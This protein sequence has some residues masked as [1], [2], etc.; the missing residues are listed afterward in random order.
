MLIEEIRC[1][2]RAGEAGC[3]V[4]WECGGGRWRVLDAEVDAA[5]AIA[6]NVA[7][8]RENDVAFDNEG[9]VPSTGVV[10]GA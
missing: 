7:R 1:L 4:C 10:G 3:D 5:S 9:R 8:N 6:E 2:R